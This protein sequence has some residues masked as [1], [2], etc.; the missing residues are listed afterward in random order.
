MRISVVIP[1]YNAAARLKL[2]LESVLRQTASPVDIIVVNDGSTDD[3]RDV[4]N[5]FGDRIQY[6][7]QPNSGQQ[8]AR[9]LGVAEA[10]GD[11]IAFLDHDDLWHPEYLAELQTFY[12]HY[13][14]FDLV[15]SNSH[16]VGEGDQRGITDRFTQFAPPGYWERLDAKPEDRFSLLRHYDLASF[17][18]FHPVQPSVM[19]ISKRKYWMIGGFNPVMRGSSVEDFEFS[20]RAIRAARGVG[21]MWQPLVTITRHAE[22]ASVDGSKSAID[23]VDCLLFVRSQPDIDPDDRRII[24]AELQRRLPNAIDGA[25]TLRDFSVIRFHQKELQSPSLKIRFKCAIAY[26]PKPL[27]KLCADRLAG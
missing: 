1:T 17:L 20:I 27:A 15:F 9:N 5:S 16:S 10:T 2:T 19:S 12:S 21:L 26:L 13:I 24:D 3:T 4:C 7:V 6:F 11:W 25:F 23:L 14:G 18:R 22:N 8:V